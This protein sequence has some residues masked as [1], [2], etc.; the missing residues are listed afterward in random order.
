MIGRATNALEPD[1]S[2]IQAWAK[3]LGISR[4]AAELYLACDVIDLHVD[5]FIWTRV[6]GYDLRRHH[7]RGLLGARYY[8][9]ADFPRMR[10]ARIT[11]ALWSITTNPLRSGS[12][13]AHAFARNVERLQGICAS[14]PDQVVLV[15]DL[16]GYRAARAAGLHAAFIAVQGG[17]A[18]DRDAHALDA[19]ADGS[20]VAVTVMH[21]SGSRLGRSSA[22]PGGRDSGLSAAGCAYVERLNALRVFV[23]L[24][25]VSRRGFFDALGV[26]DR[27]QPLLVTHT[28]VAGVTRS[29]RNIDDE[30][31][32]AVADTGGV[33]GVI[34]HGGYL[35]SP[36][37]SG[38]SAV[39]IVEHLAHIVA[40]VGEDHAALG[41]DWD[42]A[43]ITPR[44]MPTC[45]ELPRLVQ[46]MLDR[47]FPPERI[48]KLLGANFLRALGQLRG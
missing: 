18:L 11:G 7:G 13:R 41:S 36:Y 27:S 39:A 10:Q 24:A 23:D 29:W 43:I 16:D 6:I 4:E 33:V 34:F 2:D 12:G 40:T 3:A 31:L 19:L 42:G 37:W 8:S 5:S 20:V 9:Q 26:H 44:D 25:H 45:L 15:R 1:A 32:R 30:Q 17:N 35:G 48:R 28:G 22:T 38:G 21:L 47:G 14:A 46:L